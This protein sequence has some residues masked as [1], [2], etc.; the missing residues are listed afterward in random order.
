MHSLIIRVLMNAFLFVFL[1]PIVSGITFH[2]TFWPEGIVAGILFSIVIAVVDSLLFLFAVGT[3][4]LGLIAYLVFPA[5]CLE[6]MAWA[7]PQYLTIASF[8]TAIIGG[9]VFWV[10][11]AILTTAL[12][13]HLQKN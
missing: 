9:I 6:A 12:R 4:G 7:F 13:A 3:L 10:G 11:N 2:G 8:G 1:L 5:L